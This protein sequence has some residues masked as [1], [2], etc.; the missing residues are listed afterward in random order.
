MITKLLNYI[1]VNAAEGRRSPGD[2][3]RTASPLRAYA[4]EF[5]ISVFPSALKREP[6]MIFLKT[7]FGP[8][9]LK[10]KMIVKP[11]RKRK[12][13]RKSQIPKKRGEGNDRGTVSDRTYSRANVSVGLR[14]LGALGCILRC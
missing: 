4:N 13:A 7:P 1:C 11:R 14:C 2:Q 10:R 8:K 5:Y 6:K 12:A 9:G 3:Y